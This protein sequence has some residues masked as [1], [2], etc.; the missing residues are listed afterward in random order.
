MTILYTLTLLKEKLVT[1]KNVGILGGS[2][3]P[4][5]A[6]HLGVSKY[7]I[8]HLSIDYVLWLVAKQNPLKPK[9]QKDINQRSLEAIDIV[10]GYNRILV[11]TIESEIEPNNCT[12]DVLSFLNK[13]FPHIEFT[14]MMGKDCIPQFHLW[15]HFDEFTNMVNVAI[16]NRAVSADIAIESSVGY[17]T[18]L[19][20]NKYSVVF[21]DNQLIN[22]SS[23]EIRASRT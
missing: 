4:A 5:H 6:G 17:N 22:I 2:F 15:E 7:A 8:E 1:A 14:W 16:F 20:K 3:N 9:Y 13:N 23:S 10:N 12:Y 11:S 21:C 18:L 19:K